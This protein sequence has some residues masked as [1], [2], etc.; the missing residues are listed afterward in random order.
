[1][2]PV[3][4]TAVVLAAAALAPALAG[5]GSGSAPGPAGHAE[6]RVLFKSSCSGCHSLTGHQSPAK[7]G[8]DLVVARLPRPVALQYAREMPVRH[9][10]TQA[11]LAAIVDYIAAVQ[12]R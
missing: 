10:L 4:V 11:Q 6:G 1:M 7:Q 3:T 9:R 12:R 2:R 8:G 5:C